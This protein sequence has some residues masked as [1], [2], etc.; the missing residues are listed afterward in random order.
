[1]GVT[2]HRRLQ[3]EEAVNGAIGK[4]LE[5][6]KSEARLAHTEILFTVL[7]PLAEGADRLVAHQVLAC[8]RS[9]LEVVLPMREEVYLEDFKKNESKK[10]FKDLL[11]HVQVKHVKRLKARET[12][13]ESYRSAGRY[14]VDHCDVLI[15]L[16]DGDAAAGVGGTGEIVAYAVEQ[17]CPLLWIDTKQ[18]HRIQFRFAKS[19]LSELHHLDRYNAEKVDEPQIKAKFSRQYRR[20]VRR[21]T[22]SGYLSQTIEDIYKTGLSNYARADTLAQKYQKRYNAAVLAIYG[23]AAAAVGVAAIQIFEHGGSH[24]VLSSESASSDWLFRMLPGLEAF[25]MLIVLVIIQRGV[26]GNWHEKY[27]EYR[28]L[29]ESFRAAMFTALVADEHGAMSSYRRAVRSST[30]GNWV[31]LAI[32]SAWN[33]ASAPGA[34]SG[35]LEGL[36]KLLSEV[37]VQGQIAYHGSKHDA[38]R[39]KHKILSLAGGSL[40]VLAVV[41][42]LIHLFGNYLPDS[43]L[44]MT[45]GSPPNSISA[46]VRHASEILKELA[47]STHNGMIYLAIILPAVGGA[48]GAIRSHRDYKR[49]YIRCH[50]TACQ[51]EEIKQKIREAKGMESLRLH[52]R[53]AQDIMLRENEDWRSLLWFQE[54]ELP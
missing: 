45:A 19:L 26:S 38:T 32:Y 30:S 9:E 36:K 46:S 50:E 6:I 2:G 3:E 27:L 28:Y 5:L 22:Q 18:S 4:S 54:L 42:A 16:W 29:A 49:V 21:A 20:L 52:V 12:R 51:L 33:R 24:G 23:L 44:H 1:M 13:Q 10:E 11:H 37:W 35:D 34:L 43:L 53:A 48:V 41:A 14:V 47:G 7:S 17:K 39:A 25:L 31:L 8:P 40:F 15:A